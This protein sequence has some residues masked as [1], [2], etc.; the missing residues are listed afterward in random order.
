MT[1]E[2]ARTI[3]QQI[4]V[5][6]T[7][8]EQARLSGSHTVDRE[9]YKLY[10]KGRYFWGKRNQESFDRAMD[11]F[12]QAI[13]R[14]P[15]YAAPYSGLADCY[16]LFGSS[17]DVGGHPPSEVQPRA[18]AAAL[19]ALELDSSLSDAH[20]SLAYVK[21]NYDWDWPG[22]EAEFKRR[23]SAIPGTH[24]ATTGTPIFCSPAD[25]ETKLWRKAIA[26]SSSTR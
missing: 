21:L 13:D 1:D 5:K 22:A 24:T 14:D 17:F 25:A 16:V 19:K 9:A 20:K 23:S 6:L 12:R 8:E 15:S 18:K 4:Q 10:I 2:V 26:H 7:P 11:Y 3:A